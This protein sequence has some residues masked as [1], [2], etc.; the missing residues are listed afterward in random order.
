MNIL[1][2]IFSLTSSSGYLDKSSHL[3]F[4]LS[5]ILRAAEDDDWTE[6]HRRNTNVLQSNKGND[7]TQ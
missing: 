5:N 6:N 3:A 1:L 2:K 7:V 4:K